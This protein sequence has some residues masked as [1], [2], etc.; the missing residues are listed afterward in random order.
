MKN[1]YA[2]PSKL[3]MAIV[4]AAC[5]ALG[6]VWLGAAMRKEKKYVVGIAQWINNPEY[7][8]NIA[9]FKAELAKH[10]F[11]EGKNIRY[12]FETANADK[13]VQH[14]IMRKFEKARVDLVY[15]LTTPGTLVAKEE[16]GKTPIVFS[17]VTYPV[18]TGVVKS[19][20]NSECNAV[21]TRN[22]MSPSRQF[23]VFERIYSSVKRIAFVHRAGEP[24]S[25]IQYNEFKSLLSKRGIEVIDVAATDC[26]NLRA[27]LSA[28]IMN[29]DAVY[30]ACD[31]LIQSGGEEVVILVCKECSKP[32][33]TCNKDGV[34]KGALVGNVADLAEIGRISGEKAAQILGGTVP[35]WLRTEGA[36]QDYI[37]VKMKTAADLH[38]VVPDD[39]LGSANEII[40]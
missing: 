23:Y 25:S 1:T 10:G 29:V 5:V 14:G 28:I 9:S 34:N 31:T 21:G 33:F 8:K 27:K 16:L 6:A 4:L 3:V 17:I 39:V 26:A 19:L 38:C 2:V 20:S 37:I 35:Q 22:Y 30:S 11:I 24:N 32:C 7:G 40:R 18:E 15:S 12:L 36:R 13:T